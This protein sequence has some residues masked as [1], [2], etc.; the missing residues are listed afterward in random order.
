MSFYVFEISRAKNK[1]FRQDAHG[2]SEE[3]GV[4]RDDECAHPED[5]EH[6]GKLRPAPAVAPVSRIALQQPENTR[7]SLSK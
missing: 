3:L 7:W 5:D 4:E 1:I 2:S 6:L